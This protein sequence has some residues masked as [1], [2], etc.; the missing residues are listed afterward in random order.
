MTAGHVIR[1]H[2]STALP[3]KTPDDGETPKT[4]DFR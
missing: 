1:R 3:G 2:A 4:K